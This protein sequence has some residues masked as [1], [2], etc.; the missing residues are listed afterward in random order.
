MSS[1]LSFVSTLI[2]GIKTIIETLATGIVYIGS[3]VGAMPTIII[4]PMLAA[5]SILVIFAILG[6]GS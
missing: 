5:L 4:A 3:F 2:E 1:I 6:R